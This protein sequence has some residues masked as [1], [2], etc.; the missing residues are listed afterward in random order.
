MR[1]RLRITAESST[2]S[3]RMGR[4]NSITINGEAL[5]SWT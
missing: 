4:N 5:S 2:T 3:T 1:N